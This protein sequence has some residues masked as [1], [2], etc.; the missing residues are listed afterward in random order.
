[1]RDDNY[2][3]SRLDHLWDRYFSDIDQKNDVVIRFGR[4]ARTRLGSIKQKSGKFQSSN[5]P[6]TL[7]LRRTGKIQITNKSQIS[8]SKNK[9]G[10]TEFK[11]DSKRGRSQI[12]PR[13]KAGKFGMTGEGKHKPTIITINGL[14]KDKTVPEFIIDSVIAHEMVHYAHGFASPHDKK[15]DTPHA[16]GVIKKEMRERG[17][18]DLFTLQ[19][20]WLKEN[21]KDFVTEKLP[22]KVRVRRRRRRTIFVL[23]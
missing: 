17:L 8:N 14:F 2:L 12:L 5:N 20:K 21:W 13:G 4:K 1:M 18:E 9:T 16:G 10:K 19:K 22:Q 3:Q 15:H 23:R 11:I 7:K 6:T